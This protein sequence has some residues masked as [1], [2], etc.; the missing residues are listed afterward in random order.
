MKKIILVVLT[1]FFAIL[2]TFFA[3]RYL[4]Q[5]I[6]KNNLRKEID[7]I[8]ELFELDHLEYEKIQEKLNHTVTKGDIQKV[9]KAAKAYFNDYLI[10]T[11]EML[12]V[13]EDD[14]LF[15]LLTVEN[16]QEDGKEFINT[17]AYIEEAIHQLENLKKEYQE[18]SSQEKMMSYIEKDSLDES[19][20]A[21]Y[22][23]EII[24]NIDST[25]RTT[26]DSLDEF[27]HLLEDSYQV[28]IFLSSHQDAWEVV[29]D[30]VQF[31]Q[32]DLSDQYNQLLENIK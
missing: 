19:Y 23:E 27:I 25:S 6:Q 31:S 9:E 5:V 2:C 22:R 20:L 15:Q 18:L 17:K 12:D 11:T 1:L 3:G 4:N 26:E 14:R 10:F 13:L 29:D 7:S 24:G 8:V 30:H 32:K 16:Y 28:I 21:F